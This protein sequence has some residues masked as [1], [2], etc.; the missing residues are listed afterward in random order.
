VCSVCLD[1]AIY[2]INGRVEPKHCRLIGDLFPT[3]LPQI[4]IGY[5]LPVM[6]SQSIMLPAGHRARERRLHQSRLQGAHF[7]ARSAF[8]FFF[9]FIGNQIIQNN[10]SNNRKNYEYRIRLSARPIIGRP[11]TYMANI[12]VQVLSLPGFTL[13]D[14]SSCVYKN[15]RYNVVISCGLF[16]D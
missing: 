13:P 15:R 6:Y 10:D 4:Q 11:L 9:H 14:S 5:F 3:C 7:A 8:T 12:F 16:L 1:T 2:S